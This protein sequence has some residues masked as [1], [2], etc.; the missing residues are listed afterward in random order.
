MQR[1]KFGEYGRYFPKTVDIF[2]QPSTESDANGQSIARSGSF[3]ANIAQ[4][5]ERMNLIMQATYNVMGRTGMVILNEASHNSSCFGKGALIV[6]VKQTT[7]ICKDLRLDNPDI[8]NICVQKQAFSRLI[9]NL[10]R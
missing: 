2:S 7:V 4:A 1:S 5:E 3:K 6:F 10:E 9:I 8:S